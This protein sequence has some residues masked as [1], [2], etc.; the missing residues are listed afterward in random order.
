[1]PK[2]RRDLSGRDIETILRRNNFEFVR[3]KGSHKFFKHKE[4]EKRYAAVPQ[5]PDIPVGTV[6]SIKTTSQKPREEF[7]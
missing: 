2:I 7:C 5:K 4:D 6:T 3:Q 1:M